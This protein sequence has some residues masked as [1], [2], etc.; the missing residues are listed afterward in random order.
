MI[1]KAPE[2]ES[3]V[4][5]G[6]GPVGIVISYLLLKQ[7]KKVV[8]TEAGDFNTESSLLSRNSYEFKS[9]SKIPEFVHL[10][11]GGSTQWH[12]RVGQFATCDYSSNSSRP[13]E[14]PHD[15]STLNEYFQKF[16]NLVLNDSMLDSDFLNNQTFLQEIKEELP[17]C[18]DFRLYR[19]SNL[20]I[21]NKLLDESL[22]NENFTLKTNFFC[23]EIFL[24]SDS[25]YKLEY[26]NNLGKKSIIHSNNIIVACGTLQSTALLL[27]S[28][29]IQFPAR[30][31]F[32]GHN[33]MEHFDGFVGSLVIKKRNKN[34]VNLFC[35]TF[36]RKLQ[37]QNYGIGLSLHSDK[38]KEK[39]F[40]NIHL[41][42]TKYKKKFIF[43]P[44]TNILNVS[45]TKRA[46]LYFI[47]RIIRKILDPFLFAYDMLIRQNRYSV[48]IKGEEFPNYNS[49]LSLSELT[50]Q[51][52]IRKLKYSHE[53]SNITST[54][55]REELKYFS[56]KLDEFNLGM[57]RPY[58]HLMLSRLKFYVGPNWH[59]MGSTVMGSDPLNS[60]CDA[61]LE[62][63]GNKNLYLLNAGIFPTGSNQNPTAMVMAHA[64]KL[65]DHLKGNH[66]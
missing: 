25:S 27:R 59:P 13:Q 17:S 35:L 14:W 56:K 40:P 33:L 38:I 36:D 4:V 34:L 30:E 2:I 55:I 61:N 39:G 11:G 15:F 18:F 5:V 45:P 7:G 21:Y 31:K 54:K 22:L 65:V 50:D 48:W 51:Y 26:L 37:N 43:E 28:D 53:I 49:T 12:G 32:L 19:F 52:G 62:I 20:Q 60:V 9:K 29:S 10:V 64:F 24:F 42:I 16:F 46:I 47:E 63:Y 57:F 8:L 41:E 23:T 3:Y 66:S 6:A 58:R 1:S 44:R